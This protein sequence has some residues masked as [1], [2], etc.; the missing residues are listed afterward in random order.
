MKRL[1]AAFQNMRELP[2]SVGTDIKV[3]LSEHKLDGTQLSEYDITDYF[4][5]NLPLV[6]KEVEKNLNAFGSGELTLKFF[7]PAKYIGVDAAIFREDFDKE[8]ISPVF[9]NTESYDISGMRSPNM[10]VF[11]E[12]SIMRV[13]VRM[14]VISPE[15][16]P[17][18]FPVHERIFLR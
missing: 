9:R 16:H 4:D 14:H 11:P 18:R 12:E 15:I 17:S 3:Y 13:L 1:S 10:H 6:E 7:D 8:V 2:Q 5:S